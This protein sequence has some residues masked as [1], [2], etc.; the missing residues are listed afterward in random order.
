MRGKP[1][2]H[3]TGQMHVPRAALGVFDHR[4]GVCGAKPQQ[5][6]EHRRRDRP[7][8]RSGTVTSVLLTSATAAVPASR[9]D[10]IAARAAS[11]IVGA[12]GSDSSRRSAITQTDPVR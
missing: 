6:E 10:W 3:V 8:F 5:L 7:S 4:V 1:H 2:P 11:T 12:P 9:S